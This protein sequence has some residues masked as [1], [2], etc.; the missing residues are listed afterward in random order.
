MKCMYVLPACMIVYHVNVWY[1]W[2]PEEGVISL[3]LELR[4]VLWV[5]GIKYGPSARAISALNY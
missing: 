2:K 4:S 3:Y 5:L 1:T